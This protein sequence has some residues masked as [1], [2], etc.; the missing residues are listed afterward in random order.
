MALDFANI[1]SE[2]ARIASFVKILMGGPLIQRLL[3]QRFGTKF[4]YLQFL[5]FL[6]K[7][8]KVVGDALTFFFVRLL[9]PHDTKRFPI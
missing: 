5:Q 1:P 7:Y 3:E 2:D 4:V 9:N 6:A 8:R